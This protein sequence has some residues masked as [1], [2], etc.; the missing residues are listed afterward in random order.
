MV[1]TGENFGA[2]QV[3]HTML[4]GAGKKLYV[5]DHVMGFST[6]RKADGRGPQ[7]LANILSEGL[8]AMV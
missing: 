2:V 3:P 5:Y 8:I 4:F 6:I 1:V 7:D